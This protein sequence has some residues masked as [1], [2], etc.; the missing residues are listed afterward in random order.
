MRPLATKVRVGF[1]EFS[2]S[3]T[4]DPTMLRANGSPLALGAS[5][6]KMRRISLAG[7]IPGTEGR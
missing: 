2:F 3:V 5:S 1:R 4:G 6:T 7:I